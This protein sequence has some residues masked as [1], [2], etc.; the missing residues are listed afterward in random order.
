MSIRIGYNNIISI[1]FIDA[2]VETQNLAL[3]QYM[4]MFEEHDVKIAPHGNS[5]KSEGYVRTMPSVM[6]ALKSVS[7]ANTA[8]RALSF[9][10]REAGGITKASSAG[11]LPRGRQ[12]VHDMRRGLT[13]TSTMDPLFTMMMMCKDVKKAKEK[14]HLMHLFELS[15]GHHSQ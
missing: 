1:V 13:S 3:I 5:S 4:F 8:K 7:G 14:S 15:L 9:V 11:A 12:Q 10:S 2:K 6:N